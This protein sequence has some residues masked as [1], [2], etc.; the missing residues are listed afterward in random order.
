MED[1]G[2]YTVEIPYGREVEAGEKFAIVVKI[3]TPNAI[4]PVAVEYAAGAA[5]ED[6]I[7]SDGEGY[8][9]HEGTTW[10][11]VEKKQNCNVCLKVFTKRSVD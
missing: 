5:T 10:D 9:S 1:A 7:L 3:T 8:I 4:H 2:Y 6:V 11:S